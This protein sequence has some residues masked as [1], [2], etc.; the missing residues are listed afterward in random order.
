MPDISCHQEQKAH[1]E[2]ITKDFTEN[3]ERKT[4]KIGEEERKNTKLKNIVLQDIRPSTK[5]ISWNGRK[6]IIERKYLCS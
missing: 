4:M 5:R 1:M 3:I 2:H 6:K